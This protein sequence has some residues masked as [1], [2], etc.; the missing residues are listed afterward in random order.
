MISTN[1]SVYLI[2]NFQP[3]IYEFPNLCLALIDALPK[4]KKEALTLSL[5]AFSNT[6]VAKKR[7]VLQ[8]R[9]WVVSGLSAVGAL[10]PI[11]GVSLYV[12]SALIIHELN[13]YKAQFGLDNESLEQLSRRLPA[14][15]AEQILKAKS[16]TDLGT[17]EN[18]LH[19]LRSYSQSIVAEEASRFIVGIGWLVAS[20]ISFATTYRMLNDQLNRLEEASD[21]IMA[22][23]FEI[24]VSEDK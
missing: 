21:E 4:L 11:P 1:P 3:Q 10:V 20:A 9:I 18:L 19:L 22:L 24:M 5:F 15:K 2:S 23:T 7:S 16:V 13:F 8:K 12:D 17:K 6:M 14:G